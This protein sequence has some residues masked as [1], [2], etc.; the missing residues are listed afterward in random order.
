MGLPWVSRSVGLDASWTEILLRLR[1]LA[2]T[3]SRMRRT[4]A[5]ARASRA[6]RDDGNR[7][8]DAPAPECARLRK[9]RMAVRD[10]RHG[11]RS[12]L[13]RP[14]RLPAPPRAGS[15]RRVPHRPRRLRP[16]APLGT[17]GLLQPLSFP[18]PAPGHVEGGRPLQEDRGGAHPA[19]SR[20]GHA[21]PGRSALHH[22]HHRAGEGADS[23]EPGGRPAQVPPLLPSGGEGR[24]GRDRPAGGSAGP[25]RRYGPLCGR[26]APPTGSGPCPPP[27]RRRNRDRARPAVRRRRSW[28]NR[29]QTGYIGN[30]QTGDMGNSLASCPGLKPIR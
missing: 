11:H 8:E 23:R 19:R 13:R 28:F 4:R 27:S 21:A 2:E 16:K 6:C 22:E 29:V 7:R 30:G 5:V 25:D 15:A 10:C 24:L 1:V 18:S 14:P 17:V 26:G 20:G 9:V 3:C 12:R